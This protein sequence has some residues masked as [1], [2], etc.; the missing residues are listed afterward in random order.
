MESG[1]SMPQNR[2]EICKGQYRTRST[3]MSFILHFLSVPCTACPLVEVTP[4]PPWYYPTPSNEPSHTFLALPAIILISQYNAMGPSWVSIQ[5]VF[6]YLVV[7]PN[8]TPTLPLLP[9]QKQKSR[10]F[11]SLLLLI[12]L[13]CFANA[14]CFP[15]LRNNW[16]LILNYA[17]LSRGLSPWRAWGLY[18]T[19]TQVFYIYL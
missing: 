14:F 2:S 12:L 10:L 15:L 11:L 13:I 6:S 18:G 5:F 17:I 1:S 4:P 19:S 7:H 3:V 9:L 16:A 8:P